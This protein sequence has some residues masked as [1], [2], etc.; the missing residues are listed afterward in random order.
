MEKE[1]KRILDFQCAACGRM[2]GNNEAYFP[3]EGQR[4][5]CKKCWIE[6]LEAI[7]PKGVLDPVL[8]AFLLRLNTA[9][10]ERI[11]KWHEAKKET[12]GVI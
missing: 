10:V 1:Q 8:A 5:L 4:L 2:L 11:L 6:T 3:L 12:D 9:Q 7:Q